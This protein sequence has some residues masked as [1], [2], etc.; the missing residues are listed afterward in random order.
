MLQFFRDVAFVFRR[1]RAG[2]EHPLVDPYLARKSEQDRLDSAHRL[3]ERSVIATE[4]LITE[5][6]NQNRYLEQI[7]KA[8]ERG[9]LDKIK[10]L[11]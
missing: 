10:D 11:F 1:L 4:N 5:A 6:K 7:A 8:L 9:P 3:Y 2:Y